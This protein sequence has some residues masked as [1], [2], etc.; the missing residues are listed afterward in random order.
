MNGL[1]FNCFVSIWCYINY[2]C[3]TDA[4]ERPAISEI[5]YTQKDIQTVP[6][7]AR[8]KSK[9]LTFQTLYP[10]FMPTWSSLKSNEKQRQVSQVIKTREERRQSL[11]TKKVNRFNR[12]TT[13]KRISIHNAFIEVKTMRPYVPKRNTTSRK[14]VFHYHNHHHCRGMGSIFLQHKVGDLAWWATAQ[15]LLL[16]CCICIC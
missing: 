4:E 15:Q 8:S 1:V 2:F 7:K 9:K 10:Q 3:Y 12:P 5:F 13:V 16:G 6:L 11:S 14:Y